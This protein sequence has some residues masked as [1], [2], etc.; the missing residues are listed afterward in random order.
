MPFQDPK[1]RARASYN[2]I[3]SD[4]LGTG[5]PYFTD[6][7]TEASE[8]HGLHHWLVSGREWYRPLGL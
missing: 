1:N 2:V 6:G 3:G 7:E 4:E 5:V 8:N